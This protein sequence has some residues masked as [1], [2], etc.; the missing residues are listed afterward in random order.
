[1]LTRMPVPVVCGIASD[2]GRRDTYRA[3]QAVSPSAAE[4][5]IPVAVFVPG[6][7][8]ISEEGGS[9]GR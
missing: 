1:M 9:G 6:E 7:A 5:P 4:L 2:F 8:A 3:R